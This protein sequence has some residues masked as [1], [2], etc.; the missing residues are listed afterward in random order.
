MR[1]AFSLLMM[2]G[3][4]IHLQAQNQLWN[5]SLG[6]LIEVTKLINTDKDFD[7]SI[8]QLPA[9]PSLGLAL[10][11]GFSRK[12]LAINLHVAIKKNVVR[13]NHDLNY[14]V[15]AGQFEH[16]AHTWESYFAVEPLIY[17]GY[18]LKLQNNHH[19]YF[20]AGGGF[21]FNQQNT[22]GSGYQGRST[23]PDTLSYSF[24]FTAVD[25]FFHATVPILA[26]NIEFYQSFKHPRWGMV[27][28]ISNK[29]GL[30]PLLDSP[31]RYKA[32]LQYAGET[33]DYQADWAGHLTNI[34]VY[35][36]VRFS[37]F[38]RNV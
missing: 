8:Y 31:R 22:V 15:A 16:Q 24:G 17:I 28:G 29:W 36:L 23:L 11:A 12:A 27:Y 33:I 30:T 37:M 19:L 25:S 5:L 7:N 2:L 13:F 3:W 26:A 6:P 32:Q 1:L 20:G 21:A 18:Q 14:V 4:G 9:K 10:Q 35:V 38:K 34:T